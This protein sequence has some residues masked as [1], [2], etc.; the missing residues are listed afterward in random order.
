[1]AGSARR[2]PAL[3]GPS[4]AEGRNAENCG[5]RRSPACLRRQ[6][7]WQQLTRPSTTRGTHMPSL[8]QKLSEFARSP[9][10][11]Q[12]ADKAKAA[13]QDPKNREKIDRVRVRLLE[14]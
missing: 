4:G 10:G 5:G 3:I 2:S 7:A 1:M 8:S 13:A 9:K 14:K 12:L 6:R 11:Q